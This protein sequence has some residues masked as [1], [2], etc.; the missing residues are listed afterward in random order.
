MAIHKLT[1]RISFL[2]EAVMLQFRPS[3]KK[4]KIFQI[5]NG[6][7]AESHLQKSIKRKKGK[8]IR[9]ILEMVQGR[10]RVDAWRKN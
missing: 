2:P 1:Q 9:S 5:E 6:T 7:A 10:E 4:K 8:T 3:E